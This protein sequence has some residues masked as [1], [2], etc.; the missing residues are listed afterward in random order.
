M[1][2]KKKM[3]SR[4]FMAIFLPITAV[5]LVTSIVI[6]CVMEYWSTV[7]DA[8]FGEATISIDAAPGTEDWNTD[9]YNLNADGM[10]PEDTA[11]QGAQLARRAG[12]PQGGPGRCGH[13][14]QRS[15]GKL[16][17]GLVQPPLHRVDGHQGQ[18]LLHR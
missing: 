10:N 13:Q 1:T 12:L 15:P 8:V 4:K 17:P 9:Y 6:T 7:M 3:S 11:A 2:A 14:H 18:R 5:L 16:L